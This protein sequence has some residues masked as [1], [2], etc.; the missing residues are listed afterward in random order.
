[1]IV[2]VEKYLPE[3]YSDHKYFEEILE[4]MKIEIK[5]EEIPETSEI[6]IKEEFVVD[7]LA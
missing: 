3:T 4:N 6:E 2:S 7:P 1:M 5:E